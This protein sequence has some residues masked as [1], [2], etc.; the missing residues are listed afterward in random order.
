MACKRPGVRV[1]LAPLQFKRHDSNAKPVTITLIDGHFEGQVGTHSSR[2]LQRCLPDDQA[3]TR[4]KE[5]MPTITNCDG[6]RPYG[7]VACSGRY[8]AVVKIPRTWVPAARR[9]VADRHGC[10]APAGAVAPS[11]F[12]RIL[13]IRTKSWPFRMPSASA[14]RT[15]ISVR[16]AHWPPP[17]VQPPPRAVRHRPADH[18][19]IRCA[20]DTLGL[21]LSHALDER[22]QLSHQNP[23]AGSVVDPPASEHADRRIGSRGGGCLAHVEGADCP[24]L[25]G[26][27]GWA[28]ADVLW[29]GR[30][31]WAG[32]AW[33]A[34]LSCC[35]LEHLEPVGWRTEPGSPPGHRG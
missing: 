4:V 24:V 6:A 10:P 8:L 26:G 11:P 19:G 30:P 1:P 13:L 17:P 31:A 33:P 25:G 12:L 3:A 28:Q 5:Q 27:R 21:R 14:P 23:I 7:R 18:S 20:A 22:D 16:P 9:Q 35:R 29:M 2:P 32:I 34:G 15:R